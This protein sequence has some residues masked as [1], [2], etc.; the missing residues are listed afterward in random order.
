MTFNFLVGV[1]AIFGTFAFMAFVADYV[2]PHF[3][4]DGE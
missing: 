2:L 4:D 3:M 1:F